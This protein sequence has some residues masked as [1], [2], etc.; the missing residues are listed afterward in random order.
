M[1]DT[2]ARKAV[3]TTAQVQAV[4]DYV[5]TMLHKLD[6]THVGTEFDQGGR[7][8]GFA[9]YRADD[10]TVRMFTTKAEALEFYTAFAA[11][12]EAVLNHG[13]VSVVEHAS[14][15]QINAA[16]VAGEK[17][18]ATPRRKAQGETA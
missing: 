1:S 17:A 3:V 7:R 11:G 4:L 12:M 14:E 16:I 9:E 13:N 6:N 15:D 10:S 18:A 8:G 5:N 2:T